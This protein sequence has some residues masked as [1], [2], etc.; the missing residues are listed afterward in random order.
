MR[1]L[2]AYAEA[3]G[4]GAAPPAPAA[5]E[6]ADELA[7]AAARLG[8]DGDL[9]RR[10]LVEDDR[11]GRV[12]AGAGSD[13]V[14]G[15]HDPGGQGDLVD[16]ERAVAG[17]QDLQ[18]LIVDAEEGEAAVARVVHDVGQVVVGLEARRERVALRARVVAVAL[19]R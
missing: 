10:L 3:G 11:L 16:V 14:G 1:V 5:G 2:R 9:V 8:A 12:A 19:P 13:G 7:R 17:V 15:R 4:A 18:R 6:C